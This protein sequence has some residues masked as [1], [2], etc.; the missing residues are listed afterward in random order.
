MKYYSIYFTGEAH[1]YVTVDQLKENLSLLFKMDLSKIEK[2]FTGKPTII[3]KSITREEAKKYHQALT[4]A[5]ARVVV[6][7]IVTQKVQKQKQIKEKPTASQNAGPL[8]SGLAGLINYNQNNVQ[9]EEKQIIDSQSDKKTEPNTTDSDLTN[10]GLTLSLANTGSLEEFSV[11]DTEFIAPDLSAYT[12]NEANTGSLEEYAE[13]VI[14]VEIADISYMDITDQNDRPLSDQSVEQE[15]VVLPDIEQLS[16]SAVE[17]GTLQ[18]FTEHPEA[19]DTTD[20]T[21]LQLEKEK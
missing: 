5:G 18:E 11:H 9:Q 4:K 13:K 15:P 8:N 21:D 10:Q 7:E 20:F 17:S 14:A 2:L 6:K 19:L 1:D 12:L 16:I 3:K